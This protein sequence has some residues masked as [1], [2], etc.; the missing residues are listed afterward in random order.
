MR[1]TNER[2]WAL[3]KAPPLLYVTAKLLSRYYIIHTTLPVLMQRLPR[4]VSARPTIDFPKF[5]CLP[6]AL[7]VAPTLP[8][9]SDSWLHL[10]RGCCGHGGVLVS[11]LVHP[12]SAQGGQGLTYSQ[13]FAIYLWSLKIQLKCPLPD[14]VH[15]VEEVYTC[16]HTDSLLFSDNS[17]CCFYEFN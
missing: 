7:A 3:L 14:F 5:L 8:Q 10:Y 13:L 12:I 4:L 17:A 15:G 1:Q 6:C 16:L 2:T 9:T 11:P